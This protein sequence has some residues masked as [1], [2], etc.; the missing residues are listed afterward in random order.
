MADDRTT[1]DPGGKPPESDDLWAQLLHAANAESGRGTEETA[2]AADPWA[3]L[4]SEAAEAASGQP[5]D[6]DPGAAAV[7]FQ[8]DSLLLDTYRIESDPMQGGMGSVWRVHH[9]GWDAELA[10]KRPLPKMLASEK[11]RQRFVDEC[12][13]WINLGLHP[14]IVSCYYVREIDGVPAIFSEWMEN[15]DLERHIRAGTLYEG[16]EAELQA[17]LLDIAIQYARGLR[18]AHENGLIHQDVKPENLLLTKDWQAKA[19]DFGLANTPAGGYTPAYC[20]VEQ[21]DGQKLTLQTDIYSW[22][23]SVM[24]MYIGARPWSSGVIAGAGCRDYMQSQDCRVKMPPALQELLAQCMEMNADDR[25]RGFAVIEEQL[26]GIYREAAGS[27][28][29]RP[30]PKAA[31]DNASS[32]NNRA[33]SFLDL[34]KKEEAEALW[35]KATLL[36]PAHSETIFNR[37]LHGVRSGSMTLYEAQCYLSANWE[38]HFSEA[39]PGLQLAALSL[40]GG[41]RDTAENTLQFIGMMSSEGSPLSSEM[42]GKIQDFASRFGDTDFR[43]AWQISRIRSLPELDDLQRRRDAKLAELKDLVRREKYG[44]ASEELAILHMGRELGDVLYQ[45]EWMEFYE[46][47][48]RHCAPVHIL[49][50]WP[51]LRIPGVKREERVSFSEDSLRLLAGQRLYDMD[52]GELIADHGAE[53]EDIGSDM[54]EMQQLWAGFGVPSNEDLKNGL[55]SRLSPDG[56]FYLRAPSGDRNFQ[57]VDAFDGSTVRECA[58]HK[59]PVTAL[60]VSPDGQRLATGDE[61]GV[62]HLWKADGEH[63]FSFSLLP[64]GPEKIEDICF[65]GNH[66]RLAVRYE[67]HVMLYD[68][69]NGSIQNIPYNNYL[70]IDVDLLYSAMAMA[71]GRDGLGVFDLENRRFHRLADDTQERRG[72]GIYRPAKV[73][74]LPDQRIIAFGDGKMLNFYDLYNQ[75][76]LSGIHMPDSV[77]DIAASRDGRFLAVVSGGQAQVWRLV[78]LLRWQDFDP[79]N[80]ELL[81]L[82]AD[83]QLAAHPGEEPEKRLPYLMAELQERGLGNVPIHI[84][85]SALQS[86][87]NRMQ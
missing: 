43:C 16:T 33:L 45:P 83:M 68:P 67:N 55:C 73:R 44:E 78:Y 21:M 84:A 39:E 62:L 1:P 32:L 58:G 76:L 50:F 57:I 51:L 59:A 25:P 8:K 31:P 69:D 42:A 81:D 19:A 61:A 87:K 28:Y 15:G 72:H 54:K 9:V 46:D 80:T 77:D 74:F 23:V 36:E 2:P 4:L 24:E 22:A 40:E 34:G 63:L 65:A 75:K 60:A 82:C 18:Y 41:D 86:A 27:E 52:T 6:P 14:N 53:L 30:Q 38:N 3:Q 35:A 10:M 37:C 7:S 56:D 70:E 79:E 85:L 13:N 64:N 17:R 26:A 47:L 11:D 48:S 5:R 49:A 12:Q 20:S 71:I 66:N 29:P